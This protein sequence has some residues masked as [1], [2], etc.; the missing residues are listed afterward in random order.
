MWALF[1]AFWSIIINSP[2]R[3]RANQFFKEKLDSVIFYF[4]SCPFLYTKWGDLRLLKL[5]WI[6]MSLN[7]RVS[8]NMGFLRAFTSKCNTHLAYSSHVGV[9]RCSTCNFCSFNSAL[10]AWASYNKL[11]HQWF[12]FYNSFHH[13]S[14]I[15]FTPT[16]L[17]SL[18]F[19]ESCKHARSG[20]W[21]FQ[22]L[23]CTCSSSGHWS[24]WL[25]MW[26]IQVLWH[27]ASSST[28]PCQQ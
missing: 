14:L 4:F 15:H 28:I 20:S 16:T 22:S 25:V 19:P 1:H 8:S 10:W 23:C 6:F 7:L 9:K 11:C 27:H 26:F 5:L 17:T 12:P 3:K 18:W 21:H 24:A 2:S 13:T